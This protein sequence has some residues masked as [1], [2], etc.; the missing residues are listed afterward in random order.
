MAK[1]VFIGVGHG[2]NDPGAVALGREEA[3]LNL[4]IALSCR[5]ALERHGVQVLMSRT[6]DENDT[7]TDEI[8]ECNAYAPDLAIDIHNNAGGGDGAEAFYHH[9]GGL[10]KTLAENVLAEIVKI[11]QNSRGIKTK[12]NSSGAD[13]FGFIRETKAPAVIV[14]CAFVDNAKDIQIIDTEAE[15]KTMG[16]AVAKGVLATL[17]I[18]YKAPSSTKPTGK[19][20]KINSV[21]G[22]RWDNHMVLY[23]GKASTGTNKWG[24]E[25]ALNAAGVA[26]S[27]P[28]Y[29]AGNMKIPDNGCV[30]SGHGTASTWIKENIQKGT[31]LSLQITN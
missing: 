3:D 16:V 11:G 19:T 10:S 25:V 1:K 22:T 31:K 15:C 8:R 29:G 9:G 4:S 20:A 23:A 24:T 30:L 5:D 12:L 6:K 28:V 21:N 26:I 13:Y 2:G 14:E 17:G 18:A 7:L 27:A